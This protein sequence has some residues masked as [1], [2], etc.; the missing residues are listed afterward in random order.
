MVPD[1]GV[2]FNFDMGRHEESVVPGIP[3]TADGVVL[4][5]DSDVSDDL[6]A[7]RVG[8]ANIGLTVNKPLQLIKIDGLGDVG[9][10]DGVILAP[11]GDAI[12]LDR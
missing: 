10:D 5:L 12:H 1:V 9:R 7:C 2:T 3:L 8:G 11:F 6:G 4:V